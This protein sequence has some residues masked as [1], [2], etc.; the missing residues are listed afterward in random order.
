MRRECDLVTH[1]Q[2][3]SPVPK[4]PEFQNRTSGADY[5]EYC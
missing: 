1:G 2:T 4:A 5:F 3:N